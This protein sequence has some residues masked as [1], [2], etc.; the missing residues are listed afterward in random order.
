MVSL[1][2]IGM[3]NVRVD[4]LDK[5]VHPNTGTIFFGTAA[6]PI[7]NDGQGK[8]TTFKFEHIEDPYEAY[9]NLKQL[10]PSK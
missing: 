10:I 1:S 3:M 7:I 5:L 8:S 2:T 9:K 6:N 4:F